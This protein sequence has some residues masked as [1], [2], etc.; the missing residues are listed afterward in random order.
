M[1]QLSSQELNEISPDLIAMKS[2][3]EAVF[4]HGRPAKLCFILEAIFNPMLVFA[5]LWALAM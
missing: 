3:N 2:P 1:R 4:W 5:I